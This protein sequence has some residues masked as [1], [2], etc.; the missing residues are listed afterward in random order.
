M[1]A[2]TGHGAPSRAG[3]HLHLSP[4][5]PFVFQPNR[6]SMTDTAATLAP[7]ATLPRS[8]LDLIGATPLVEVTHF[9][10]GPCRLFLKLESQ[11]PGGSI[12]DRVARSMIDAA[13]KEGLIKPGSTLVEATAGN[14]GLALTLVGAQRGYKVVLVVPDK[15]SQEKIFALKAL[16]ARV[17]MTRSDV[18][19][20][21]PEYYQDMAQR[22]ASEI[23]GAWYVNQFGNPNNPK[24]HET[25][26]GPELWSQLKGRI[27]AVVCGVGSGGTLTGLT[28]FFR[29]KS[30]RVKMVLADPAGSVLADYVAHGYIKEAG[31]WLVEGIGEDFIPPICDLTGV[32][33]AYT[34]PDAES[35][36]AAR[37]LL[38]KEGIMGG[39]STG[40]LLAAA[41]RYCRTRTKPEHVVT[42]VCDHGNRYLS[43]MYNDFWMSDQGFL[44]KEVRGDLRDIIGRR[45]DE[46]AVVTVAP[47]DTVLTAYGR[48]KLYD[49]SQLPVT[50]DE[51]RI[52]GLIDE[53][54]LLLAITKDEAN[55][56]QPV[57]KF[58]TSRLTTL[59]PTAPI[60]DLLPLFD[61]GL[62]PIVVDGDRF[63]GLVTR[64]DLLNHLR[65]KLKS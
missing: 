41:L 43:K 35:F 3:P 52:V 23:P 33:E 22:L 46:G 5:A 42:F 26:T 24:A 48:F 15:M 60:S 2:A 12:K 44:P 58:M 38:R 61:Q 34:V 29:Q 27:D 49:V 1:T 17:V 21:H 62:V 16:G 31:S 9:D 36:A 63:L 10:T 8:S 32:R 51:G 25:G 53:S 19:V 64:I 50:N 6:D 4:P 59:P 56:R 57:K 13:E 30:P 7:S 54:D 65:R 47:T 11:N 39:S 40:T 37:E 14:T 55:F 18:G 45:A 20:G 28:R